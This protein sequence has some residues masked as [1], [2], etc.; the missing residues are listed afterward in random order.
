[1]IIFS[2]LVLIEV[3]R[4]DRILGLDLESDKLSELEARKVFFQTL[5]FPLQSVCRNKIRIIK[6]NVKET[7]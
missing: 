3:S 4:V 1:M 7:F 6:T 2:L 5:A